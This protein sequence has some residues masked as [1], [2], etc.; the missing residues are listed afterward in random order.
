MALRPL[1][2]D[3]KEFIDFLNAN[4]VCYLLVGG[5][6]VGLHGYP[7]ATNDID[8][9]IAVDKNNLKK[10]KK[11][12]YE[13]HAP[14]IDMEHFRKPGNFFRMG[15]SPVQID[16]IA[17]AAGIDIKECYKRRMVI[18]VKGTDISVISREDLIKNKRATGRIQD[19]AD[20]QSLEKW[21]EIKRKTKSARGKTSQSEYSKKHG[22]AGSKT[23]SNARRQEEGV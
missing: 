10:L 21:K 11:A 2:E 23:P 5:W 19:L 18:N 15:R 9:L 16:I 17:D 7:R 8:F 22:K 12:L 14:T 13:F 6:A 1:P 4:N 3:F 20:A